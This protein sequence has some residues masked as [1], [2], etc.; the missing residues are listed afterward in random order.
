M[1]CQGPNAQLTEE[2]PLWHELVAGRKDLDVAGF[3]GSDQFPTHKHDYQKATDDCSAALAID[4]R[5]TRAWCQRASCWIALQ[6]Y[7]KAI[8]DADE[9]LRLIALKQSDRA[10]KDADQFMRLWAS[11]LRKQAENPK[12][13]EKKVG[14][15]VRRLKLFLGKGPT[16]QPSQY[17]ASKEGGG[18]AK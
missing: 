11:G 9:A 10:T 15:I 2:N 17:P 12:A 4:P 3:P 5:D 16:P 14:A 7:D 13:S 18:A 8:K 6:Q 1:L